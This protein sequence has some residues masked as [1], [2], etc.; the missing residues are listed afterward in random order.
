MTP[1]NDTNRKPFKRF[2]LLILI[3]NHRAEATVLIRKAGLFKLHHFRFAKRQCFHCRLNIILGFCQ[4]LFQ[5]REETAN[6]D[7]I[8]QSVMHFNGD[9]Q[10][11][12]LALFQEFT[13]RNSR[14]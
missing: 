11:N 6:V 5:Q 3:A 14:Y 9:W 1:V 2:P 4:G 13:E 8:H 12:K 7:A 10:T